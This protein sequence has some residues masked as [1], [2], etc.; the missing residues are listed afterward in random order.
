[1]RACREIFVYRQ[2]RRSKSYLNIWPKQMSRFLNLKKKKSTVC[3]KS[4]DPILYSYYTNWVRI[5]WA[6][7]LLLNFFAIILFTYLFIFILNKKKFIMQ[8]CSNFYE[9]HSKKTCTQKKGHPV[10]AYYLDV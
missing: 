5:S 10:Q 4:D 6:H 7:F 3:P 1:M 8:L 9:E 2:G